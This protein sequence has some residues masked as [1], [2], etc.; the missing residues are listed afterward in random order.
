MAGT[1][2]PTETVADQAQRSRSIW[3]A[4]GGVLLVVLVVL[5]SAF[6][7]DRYFRP[8]VG[9]EPA[10][11]AS[12]AGASPTAPTATTP[13]SSAAGQGAVVTITQAADISRLGSQREREVARAY[14]RYWDVYAQAM[15]TLDTSRLAEV[16]AGAR[17]QEAVEEVG[18]LKTEGIAARIQVKHSFAVNRASEDEATIRDEYVNSSYAINPVSKQPVGEP[19]TSERLLDTY[20]LR[21]VDG[22]WKVI[23]GQKGAA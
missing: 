6:A 16:T 13:S 20:F 5:G 7:L 1:H 17:H 18:D 22:V 19:G 9:I 3:L 15:E 14:L 10:A 4:G 23:G 8:R 12:V 2:T 11:G 21:R